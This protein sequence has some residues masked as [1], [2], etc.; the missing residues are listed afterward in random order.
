MVVLAGVVGIG[1]FWFV[2]RVGGPMPLSAEA[3]AAAVAAGCDPDVRM[4]A[5]E[6]PGNLHLEPGQDPG[7][8]E[9]PATSGY[10]AN[11]ELVADVRVLAGPVDESQAVHTLEHGSVIVYHRSRGGEGVSD[12]V[13]E[14]LGEVARENPAT[15]LIPYPTLP[16]E[17]GLAFTAWNKI[18]T[19]PASID[20][21][22]AVTIAQGFVDSFACTSNAPEGKL[23]DGC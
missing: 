1:A 2:N 17:T 10:H 3:I 20:P 23:G 18:L 14:R 22:Q 5:T 19:C 13:L 12:E 9:S 16:E 21:D 4:P 8:T 7:Y 11:T 15:Y 6:A